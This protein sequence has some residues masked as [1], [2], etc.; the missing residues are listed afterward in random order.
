MILNEYY[1]RIIYGHIYYAN[2]NSSGV[3]VIYF[4]QNSYILKN[5]NIGIIYIYTYSI[6]PTYLISS[7]LLTMLFL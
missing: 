1:S 5:I 4:Q 3:Y 2:K 7:I 6:I